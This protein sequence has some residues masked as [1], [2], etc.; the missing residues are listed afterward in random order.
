M[1]AAL[2][3]E[4]QDA[5]D[6]HGLQVTRVCV[7]QCVAVCCSVLQCVAFLDANDVRRLQVMCVCVRCS[8][9]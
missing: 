9:L 7:L 5:D 4:L 6:V 1:L 8:V 2:C 3:H